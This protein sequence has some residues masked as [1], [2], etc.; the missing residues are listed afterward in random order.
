MFHRT[1]IEVK[2]SGP[3]ST[4]L[5]PISTG[6]RAL[7]FHTLLS[8]QGAS[9]GLLLATPPWFPIGSRRR[10]GGHLISGLPGSSTERPVALGCPKGAHRS[11]LA[12]PIGPAREAP[13]LSRSRHRP[14]GGSSPSVPGGPTVYGTCFP[15]R[16]A[17]V[18]DRPPR[19]HVPPT[20]GPTPVV[21]PGAFGATS[22]S[23]LHTEEPPCA[24][25]ASGRP[26]PAVGS[27][28][29][30][31]SVTSCLSVLTPS[32]RRRRGLGPRRTSLLGA[33]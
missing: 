24:R 20:V 27:T 30:W 26:P 9:S 21:P 11:T 33:R 5:L 15:L 28:S 31:L 13:T 4:R 22:P 2:R 25:R 23:A 19:S 32:W 16:P 6:F 29:R 18:G 12:V 17:T 10:S 7:A 1:V 3:R 14:D 8:F